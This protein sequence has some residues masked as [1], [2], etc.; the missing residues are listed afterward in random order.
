MTSSIKVLVL[1]A[2]LKHDSDT[3]NTQEV[4]DVV[5]REMEKY[6]DIQT[7]IIR[8]SDKNIPVG[9]KLKE[10]EDDEWPAI[11]EMIKEA[12]VVIFATPIWWGGR[13]SLLQRIIERMDAFDEDVLNGGRAVLLNKVAGIV[14]TGSED[15]AQ[16]VM[17]STMSTLSFLNFTL[18]PNCCTYW[19]GE[20]GMDPKTDA[21]RRRKSTAVVHMAAATAK[22]IMYYAQLLRDH[23]MVDTLHSS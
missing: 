15:G 5:L 6:G 11:A 1:N 17:A 8:L 14:I 20:V 18:P 3:S 10:S 12:D 23:P 16:A 19:V 7:T 22:G 13:S 4:T 9:L 21:E 2:S